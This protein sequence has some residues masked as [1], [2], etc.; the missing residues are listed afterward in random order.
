MKNGSP[1]SLLP[2]HAHA[3]HAPLAPVVTAPRALI[4]GLRGF[5]G[6]YLA[7][8]LEQSGYQ[9]FGTAYGDEKLGDGVYYVDLCDRARLQ[10]IVNEIQPD[11]VAHLAAISFVGHDNPGDFHRI[12]VLGTSNLLEALANLPNKP[13]AILVASS[14]NI[15][16]NCKVEVISEGEPAMPA[17]D[18]AASKLAME[19]VARSWMDKLPI[20]ITRPF[21]YVGVGQSENFLLPKIVSHFKRKESHIEL[22]NLDVARDFSDVRM[23]ARAYR[24]LLQR[25]PIGETFNIC[26]GKAFTLREVIQMVEEQAG[27]QIEVRVNP[28]FV[29][30]NEIHKLM[31]NPEKLQD[32]LGTLPQIALKDTLSWMLH[33]N[34]TEVVE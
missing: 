1:L 33:E 3:T 31:G 34:Q 5:T 11:I 26:S 23:V 12:N 27:Y 21:N 15:Y 7:R 10:E 25:A 30:P 24:E 6:A 13:Q 22:G 14:A 32:C 18:Y 16:G 29:R 17:N 19:K 2:I 20:F 4:T 9:V 8:E 28:A